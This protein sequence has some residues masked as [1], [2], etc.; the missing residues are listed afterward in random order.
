MLTYLKFRNKENSFILLFY[1]SV[2]HDVFPE[3]DDKGLSI[4]TLVKMIEYL[5]E[6]LND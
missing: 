3:N 6:I 2:F 5:N 4:R 1:V